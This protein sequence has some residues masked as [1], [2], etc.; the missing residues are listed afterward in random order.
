MADDIDDI[1]EMN[2][3]GIVMLTEGLRWGG[4]AFHQNGWNPRLIEGTDHF[5]FYCTV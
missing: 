1:Y 2:E 3:K 4:A 5:L